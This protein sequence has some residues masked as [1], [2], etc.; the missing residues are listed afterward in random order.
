[1][2]SFIETQQAFMAHIRDP[3]NQPAPTGI[4]PRRLKIYQELFFNNIEG[5]VS[6]AFPVL[7]SLYSDEAWLQ[8]IRQ[9]FVVHDCQTPHFLEISK[10]FLLFLQT[11][12]QP[13]HDDPCFVV[14][15]AHYEWLELDVATTIENPDEQWLDTN[16]LDSAALQ[17]ASTVRVGHYQYPVHQITAENQPQ[18]AD[19]QTYSFALYRDDED[20]VQFI[21][22][23]PMTALLLSLIEM[24]PGI[25]LAE[26]VT[27]IQQQAP[28]FST[29][30]LQQ[31]AEQTL[32]E[33]GSRGILVA[34]V[35]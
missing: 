30:Q 31:G 13:Q 25:T 33:F 21:A 15:L 22:L 14:E 5:F 1:M 9:F 10:E 29:Q 4:E 18:A 35:L 6:S 19:G 27:E 8:L 16:N 7:K 20:E 26:L 23:N 3:E 32:T 2:M 28:Q 11:E 12:Y 34:K 17:L 24:N